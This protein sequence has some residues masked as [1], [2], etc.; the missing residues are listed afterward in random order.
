M[1]LDG[2]STYMFY[3]ALAHYLHVSVAQLYWSTVAASV[4]VAVIVMIVYFFILMA[5]S[6]RR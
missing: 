6:K 5:R 4:I 2:F 1:L 3:S